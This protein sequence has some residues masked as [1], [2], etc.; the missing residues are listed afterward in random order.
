MTEKV[1]GKNRSCR[2]L[3]SQRHESL[4]EPLRLSLDIHS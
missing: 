3:I 4:H 2:P 1:K